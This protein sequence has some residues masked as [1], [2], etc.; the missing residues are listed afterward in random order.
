MERALF[1]GYYFP[2]SNLRSQRSRQKSFNF[3]KE[4]YLCLFWAT[5]EYIIMGE[6]IFFKKKLDNIWPTLFVKIG[7]FQVEI[8][9]ICCWNCCSCLSNRL[10]Q[11]I[12]PH[13]KSWKYPL[14][15]LPWT[16]WLFSWPCSWFDSRSWFAWGDNISKS[17]WDGITSWSTCSDSDLLAFSFSFVQVILYQRH[18]KFSCYGEFQTGKKMGKKVDLNPMFWT[19][20]LLMQFPE[21]NLWP[22]FGLIDKSLIA[23]DK[24]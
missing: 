18:S 4:H 15:K 8:K 16:T 20:V 19:D 12:K 2:T 6:C 3:I 22:Y 14:N 23:F 17:F 13:L 11:Q 9:K 7:F 21:K 10:R 5:F 24:E 1:R